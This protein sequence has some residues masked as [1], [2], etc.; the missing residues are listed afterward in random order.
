MHNNKTITLVLQTVGI[1]TTPEFCWLVSKFLSIILYFQSD[2][3]R[4][5]F[6]WAKY[7]TKISIVLRKKKCPST[8]NEDLK[9][10][11]LIKRLLVDLKVKEKHEKLDETIREVI[12]Y[13]VFLWHWVTIEKGLPFSS[14]KHTKAWVSK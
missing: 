2:V 14:S 9:K 13:S 5:H 6:T 10:W 4:I 8:K 1:G 7:V 12:I 11:R 3:T